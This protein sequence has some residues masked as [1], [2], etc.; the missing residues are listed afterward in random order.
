M[1]IMVMFDLPVKKKRDRR[2]YSEFRKFLIKDG[3]TM[4]QYSVYA[5]ITRNHDD[6]YKHIERLKHNL[7]PRGSV[8][9]LPITENQYAAMYV[10]VGQ[11]MAEEDYLTPNDVLEI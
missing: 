8:R 3:Y 1:R 6:M 11:K 7:P 10:L 4:L 2:N 9:V 5:R